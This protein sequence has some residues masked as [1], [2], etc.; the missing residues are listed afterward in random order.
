[1]WYLKFHGYDCLAFK[2]NGRKYNP[3]FNNGDK[4]KKN[5]SFRS[6]LSNILYKIMD[7]IEFVQHLMVILII[8]FGDH[9]IS[10]N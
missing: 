1:M 6:S 7:R 9:H 5:G 3:T 8:L 4:V 10:K 2:S